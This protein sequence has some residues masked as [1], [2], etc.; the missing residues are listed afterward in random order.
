MGFV[1]S[2]NKNKNKLTS[3]KSFKKQPSFNDAKPEG[4]DF[5]APSI[6]KETLPKEINDE[7]I[8]LSDYAVEIGGTAVPVRYFRSFFAEIMSGNTWAGMLDSLV[9]GEFGEG[10]VDIAVHVR[11][12]S[13]NKELDEIGRRIAGLLSDRA[14]E[15]NVSK[16]DAMEDEIRDL[17][18]RQQRIRMNIERS[19]RVSIQAVASGNDWS[20]LKKY[21]NALVN[22]FGGKSIVLRSADG[23][24]LDALKSILPTTKEDLVHKEHFFSLETSNVADLFLFG[25]GGISHRTGIIIGKDL[26]GRPTWLDGWHPSLMNQHMVIMGRSG[27]GKTYS[28]F[29]IIHRS[30]HIG[31]HH[32]IIDWKGEYGDFLILMGCP[33]I[34]FSETSKDRI[35]PYDV[36]ITE[37]KNGDRYVDIEEAVN[38]VQAIVFKMITT[39]ERSDLTGEVKVFINHAIREQYKEL[40]ITRDPTSI[41]SSGGFNNKDRFST[42]KLKKMPELSGLYKKMK[43]S[44]IEDVVKV[45][46]ILKMFTKQGGAPSYSIFDGQ[47]TVK[48]KR[49]PLFG[50]AINKLDPEIMRPLGLAVITRWTTEKWAKKY[51]ELKKR[52]VIEECQNIFNDEDIGEVWAESAYREHRSTNTSICAISQGLEVYTRSKAGV[53][54]VKNSP[55]KLIGIQEPIDIESVRGKLDLSEGEA[56]YLIN[57]AGKGDLIVK[58]DHESTAVHVDTTD[59]E[60]LLF[61]SDPNDPKYWERKELVKNKLKQQELQGMR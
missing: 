24:Q 52:L 55:I 33:Y 14:E 48:L 41:Y 47:S 30:V 37:E 22:L 31:I 40:E 8:K 58:L 17:K 15:K 11:P 19:Y 59:Y 20:S 21:C 34:E 7:G 51:P 18:L 61:T 5:A 44:N 42:R 29:T 25:L 35:N 3:L 13:N 45:S 10:D 38:N 54:A 46:K 56:N 1:R 26:I 39:Y 32:C 27:A 9:L 28:I 23:Y 49:S 43:E 36:D 57:E 50:F 4:I 53:A 16:L 60:H 2:K 12:A 6:I